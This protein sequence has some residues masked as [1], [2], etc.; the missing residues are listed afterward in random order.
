MRVLFRLM[1][2]IVVAAI[3]TTALVVAVVPQVARMVTSTAVDGATLPDFAPLSQKSTMYDAVG[4]VIGQ[5]AAENLVP[6]K[7]SQ[8]PKGVIDAVLAVEDESFYDH[9]GVN[10]KSLMRAVLANVSAG[11]VLQ[12]GSTITQQV[13]KNSYLT[14]DR[15]A[16]RKM[17][18]A[19]YAVQLE[20]KLTKNQI[21][22]R[23]LNSVY[24]GNGAY[25]IEAAAQT[26]FGKPVGKLTMVDGAF[27]AGLIRNPAGYDPFK[28]PAASKV[29][30]RVALERLVA[31]GHMTEAAGRRRRSVTAPAPAARHPHH[32]QGH[33][34]LRRSG[35]G[36]PAQQE[37]HPRR[38]SPAALQRLLP[39]RAEDLHHAQ[40]RA[41]GG[42][43]AGPPRADA[44][45]ERALR[46]RHR[47]PQ[48]Q[49][50]CRGG[51]G[52]RPRLRSAPAQPDAPTAPDG[53]ER[54]VHDPRLRARGGRQSNDLIDGTAPCTLPN[55]PDP[56]HPFVISDA[57]SRGVSPLDQQTWFSIDCAYGRLALGVGLDRVV[58]VMKRMGITS[59]LRAVPALA[60]GNNEI[61]PIDMASAFSGVADLGVHHDPYYI[62][63]IQDPTGKVIYQ[64]QDPGRQVLDPNVAAQ[65]LDILKGVL[66][67][68]TGRRGLLA[69]GR[70]AAGK[71]GTQ[72]L[73]TNAW[74][75]GGTPQ[76][77]TAVWMGNWR[78]NTDRMEFIPQFR[79]FAKV[80]GGT[81]PVL[82][83]KA[84]MDAAHAGLPELDWPPPAPPPRPPARL[85]LPGVDCTSGGPLLTRR[86]ATVAPGPPPGAVPP[87]G[88]IDYSAPIPS[89]PA[90]VLVYDCRTGPPV[91]Q[92]PP[93]T[94]SSTSSTSTASSSPSST[95]APATSN[96]PPKKPPKK[97][98]PPTTT[99]P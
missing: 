39:R 88:P 14:S 27:L 4:N 5:F 48:H 74:F 51:D 28:H 53:L 44:E 21:L 60:T 7:I 3:G 25:G 71:T 89:V 75:V 69:G 68:G 30:R 37:Q 97:R 35:E 54:Q 63:S 42:G 1:I 15:D 6:V 31:T 65:E 10:A 26:Y 19:A 52:G 62:E 81:Y 96:N 16:S 92:P 73:N 80:Q 50:R 8:V 66:R 93:T 36:N 22:E 79:Q 13:V 11:G 18:E 2:T 20:K 61:S 41:A 56:S 40:P 47:Q 9:K 72:F 58:G 38:R 46:L 98:R 24:F 85:Y 64:H 82:I 59:T 34:L 45:H 29:R 55:P 94:P 70:P 43:R 76:Y 83:W 32:R 86:A 87:G 84:Y 17:L 33:L 67:V 90:G 12:G 91:I 78:N 49:D 23:Y 99:A 95:N 57:T 77:T